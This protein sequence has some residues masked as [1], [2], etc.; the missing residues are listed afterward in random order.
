[1][2]RERKRNED[3]RETMNDS[4]VKVEIIEKSVRDRI[5]LDAHRAPRESS[6]NEQPVLSNVLVTSFDRGLVPI[7]P[8]ERIRKR[9]C[10]FFTFGETDVLVLVIAQVWYEL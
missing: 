2:C 1:M 5:S 4:V 10:I 3:N 9:T 6:S 8:L 7:R